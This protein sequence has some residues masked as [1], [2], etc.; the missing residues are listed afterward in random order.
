MAVEIEQPFG[1]DPD[2]LPLEKFVL[3]IEENLLD[4]R[5]EVE[6]RARPAR[7]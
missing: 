1:D 5:R 4:I 2:D 3:N 6:A 7:P